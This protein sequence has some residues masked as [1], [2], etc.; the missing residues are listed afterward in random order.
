MELVCVRTPKTVGSMYVVMDARCAADHGTSP[1]RS[2]RFSRPMSEVGLWKAL[3]C[4]ISTNVLIDCAKQRSM[5]LQC[6]TRQTQINSSPGMSCRMHCERVVGG[7]VRTTSQKCEAIL[8]RARI[9]GSYSC[10]SL[11]SRLD[12][13]EEDPTAAPCEE[14]ASN[15][16]YRSTSL[17]RN[18][19]PPR[20]TTG[21]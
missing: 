19:P 5:L 16:Q 13:K 8:M 7:G 11:N 18:N 12:S 10:V 3:P 21:P 4:S 2:P 9:Q 1:H 6:H 15:G 17:I 14:I 20:I